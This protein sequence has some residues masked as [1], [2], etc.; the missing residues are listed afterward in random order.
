MCTYLFC[1]QILYINRMYSCC[2]QVLLLSCSHSH[3]QVSPFHQCSGYSNIILIQSTLHFSH[4][5]RDKYSL[6]KLCKS[7]KSLREKNKNIYYPAIQRQ[8][9]FGKIFPDSYT[10]YLLNTRH[11]QALRREQKVRQTQS[12]LSW[13]FFSMLGGEQQKFGRQL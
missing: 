3:T 5:K 10:Q 2:L 12:L 13:S 8:Q 6:Q 4:C 7:K 11:C 9:Y 1:L